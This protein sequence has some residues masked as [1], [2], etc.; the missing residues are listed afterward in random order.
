M[1]EMGT[2]GLMLVA[3]ALAEGLT[4]VSKAAML[5]RYGAPVIWA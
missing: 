1:L 3:Q 2:S 4:L 5:A